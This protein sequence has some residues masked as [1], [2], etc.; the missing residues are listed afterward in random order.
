VSNQTGTA[1]LLNVSNAQLVIL[2][3]LG[4]KY[5]LLNAPLISTGHLL[6]RNVYH[7]LMVLS[8]IQVRNY[9]KLAPQ[10]VPSA[11]EIIWA[12]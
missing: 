2:W 9:A 6:T 8:T 10:T 4:E 1:Q 3:I 7:A 5:V 11:T 12:K